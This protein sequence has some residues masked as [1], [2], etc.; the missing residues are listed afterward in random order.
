MAPGRILVIGGGPAGLTTALGLAELSYQVVVI[1]RTSYDDIRVGEHIPPSATADLLNLVPDSEAVLSQCH[2]STGVEAFWGSE[3]AV[4][5]DYFLRPSQHG[6]NLS[7]PAFD[8]YLACACESKGVS[9]LRSS[10]LLK[11]EL[12][13]S[14]WNVDIFANDATSS[15]SAQFL[16]DATG[17]SASFGTTRGA[18]LHIADSQIAL[19]RFGSVVP[20]S[21]ITK[22]VLEATEMGWWYS[23]PLGANSIICMFVTDRELIPA[24]GKDGLINWWSERLAGTRQM[25]IRMQQC[26]FESKLHIR[27]ACS[28]Y[29]NPPSGEGWMAV[30]DAAMAIDPLSSRGIAKALSHGSRAARAIH[31]YLSGDQL[32]LRELSDDILLEYREYAKLRLAYYQLETRWPVSPFWNR[33]MSSPT[34]RSGGRNYGNSP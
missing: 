2:K 21:L 8:E 1:E 5:A 20:E 15:T 22:S 32:P 24:S 26:F 34:E 3:K 25:S 16:V 12:N 29:L 4:Y 33:R 10:I 17:R 6:F 31:S 9:I 7:R 27:S 18:T 11:S 30:G 13:R 14:D 23:A 28:Q 19:V